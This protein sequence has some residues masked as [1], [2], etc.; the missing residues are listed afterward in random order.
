MTN[1]EGSA[2]STDTDAPPRRGQAALRF[3][4]D[5]VIIIVAAIIISFLIKTFLIRSFY[6]PSESMEDTLLVNDRIIV[7][8]LEPGLFPI[9]RGDVVVFR[10]PGGWLG[11]TTTDEPFSASSVFEWVLSLV[12]LA[13]PDSDEHLIKRVIGLPGDTVTCCD[14]YGRMSINGVPIDETTYVRLPDDVVRVSA[15]DFEVTVPDGRVWVMGDNR[16][17]SADSRYNMDKPGGGFVP[18]DNVVG[19]AIVISWP[20]DRWT[21]LDNHPTVFGGITGVEPDSGDPEPVPTAVA[22]G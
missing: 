21:W 4:R 17:R 1:D 10:D 15:E 8:Q 14:D 7:N 9:S 13:A 2:A 20:I 3:L 6:I 11:N 18:I 12:G 19:R 22:T 16:Y 5:V